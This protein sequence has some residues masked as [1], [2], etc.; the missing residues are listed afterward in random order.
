ML[1]ANLD[2]HEA[3]TLSCKLSRDLHATS[4]NGL[5]GLNFIAGC[6]LLI[7]EEEDAFWALAVIVED[8]LPGYFSF[9]MVA[10]QVRAQRVLPCTLSSHGQPHRNPG[11]GS[12]IA[13]AHAAHRCV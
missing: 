9:M 13:C 1:K 5:Q 3:P 10:P 4:C 7:M 6:L 8:L 11:W 12:T 2:N